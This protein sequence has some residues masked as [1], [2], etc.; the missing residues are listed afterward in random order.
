VA[1]SIVASIV[2]LLFLILVLVLSMH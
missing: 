2:L 1:L